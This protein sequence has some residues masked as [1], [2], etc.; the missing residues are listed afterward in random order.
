[1][2]WED[3]LVEDDAGIMAAMRNSRRLAILG[4]KPDSMPEQPAQYVPAYLAKVGYDVVPVPVYYP[5]VTEILGL[6]VTR[7]LKQTGPVDMIVVFRRSKDIP[8][9]VGDM[10]AVKPK[11]VWFQLGIRNDQAAEQLARAGIKVIQD[12]CTMVEHGRSNSRS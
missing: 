1:M 10:I 2:D 8:P 9:H 3:N 4:I 7:D 6:P 12:R 11:Y 5:E